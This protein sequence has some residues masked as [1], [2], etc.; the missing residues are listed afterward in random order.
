MNSIGAMADPWAYGQGSCNLV[1][2]VSWKRAGQDRIAT[3]C[4]P[5]VKSRLPQF[6]VQ[7]SSASG[8][9]PHQTWPGASYSQRALRSSPTYSVRGVSRTASRVRTRD[10]C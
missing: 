4:V 3:A 5:A 2:L 1:E 10:S 6:D 8:N 7:T 9:L